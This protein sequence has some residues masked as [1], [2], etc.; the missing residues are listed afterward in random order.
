MK[1]KGDYFYRWLFLFTVMKIKGDIF[2]EGL[3]TQVHTHTHKKKRKKI[4]NGDNIH[5]V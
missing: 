5:P 2:F 4:T 3:N 1:I